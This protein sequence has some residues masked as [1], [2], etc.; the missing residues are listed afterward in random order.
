MVQKVC[1]LCVVFVIFRFYL[2]RWV[3]QGWLL[4]PGVPPGDAQLHHEGQVG[5][6][7]GIHC[8]SD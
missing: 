1:G 5:E 3:P 8:G 4:H 6:E 7:E 2:D